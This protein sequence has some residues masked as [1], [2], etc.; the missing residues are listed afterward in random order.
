MIVFIRVR[1]QGLRECG[2]MLRTCQSQVITSW[3][4]GILVSSSSSSGAISKHYDLQNAQLG[5]SWWDFTN[6]SILSISSSAVT[7]IW[8][9]VT[10]RVKSIH[11]IWHWPTFCCYNSFICLGKAF[12]KVSSL[13]YLEISQL[14]WLHRSQYYTELHWAPGSDPLFHKCL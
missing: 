1:K 5:A 13:P 3:A 6:K 12:H 14:D 2:H 11:L 8:T 7:S 4:W 10:S 9:R